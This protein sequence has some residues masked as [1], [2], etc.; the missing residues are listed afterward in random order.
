VPGG[1]REKDEERKWKGERGSEREERKESRGLKTG[2][3]YIVV[4]GCD[5]DSPDHQQPVR[6]RHVHLLMELGACVHRLDVR[7]VRHPHHLRQELEAAG[8]HG[9][10][11]DNGRQHGDHHAEVESPWR[12][13]E[14]EGI[15]VRR[16]GC[17]GRDE[18]CL[19]NVRNKKARKG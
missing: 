14:E 9:L 6:Q 15:G 18:R 2:E 1:G 12:H 3:A 13:G 8:D 17:I 11:G 19:A 16:A 7:E 5:N 4:H 10:R